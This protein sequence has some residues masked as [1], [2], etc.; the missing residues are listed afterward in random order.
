MILH[1][2]AGGIGA[3]VLPYF[4]SLVDAEDWNELRRLLVFYS[5]R[6]LIL[7]SAVSIILV[8]LSGPLVGFALERGVFDEGDTA[9]VGRI[10]AAYALQ[11]PFYICG[12]L[13]V[14]VISSMIANHVLM[15]GSFLNLIVN[16]SPQL[17]FH[18]TMG[19]G[20]NRTV[21]VRCILVFIRLSVGDGLA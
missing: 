13:F 21:D 2:A 11:I 12:I 9:L 1:I 4:S 15:I 10:Q 7:S 18:A 19:C 16:I 17:R 5:K 6:I 8:T 3:A 14:R 20:G